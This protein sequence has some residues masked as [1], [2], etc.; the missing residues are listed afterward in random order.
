[1]LG[2]QLATEKK[3]VMMKRLTLLMVW[4]ASFMSLYAQITIDEVNFPDMFFHI[5]ISKYDK[6][7]DRLLSEEEIASVTKI[8]LTECWDSIL[9]GVNYFYNLEHLKISSGSLKKLDLSKNTKLKY[10]ELDAADLSSVLLNAPLLDTLMINPCQIG[11]LDLSMSSELSYLKFSPR[12]YNPEGFSNL[13]E[14]DL[15]RNTKLKYLELDVKNLSSLLLNAPLLDTLIISPCHISTLD[16]NMSTQ[17]SFLKFLPGYYS[18]EIFSNLTELDLRRNMKLKYLELDAK[19]L[20]SLLLNT[21]LLDT[22]IIN[23]CQISSLDLSVSSELSYL[24]CTPRRYD[25]EIFSNLTELDLSRNTKLQYLE[26]DVKNLSSLLLNAP[27]LDTL[28]IFPCKINNLDLSASIG[29]TYLECSDGEL[30]TL[31]LQNCS[32]LK[33]LLCKNNYIAVLNLNENVNLEYFEGIQK[34]IKILPVN[35]CFDM[36]SFPGFDIGRSYDWQGPQL[37][38]NTIVF[39]K[40][41]TSAS[42]KYKTGATCALGQEIE[43]NLFCLSE[44]MPYFLSSIFEPVDMK[45]IYDADGDGMKEFYKIDNYNGYNISRYHWYMPGFFARDTLLDLSGI[46]PSSDFFKMLHLNND[47]IPDFANDIYRNFEPL[48]IAL[49]RQDGSYELMNQ[50][51]MAYPLDVNNDGL[52]DLFSLN[53]TDWNVFYQNPDGSYTVTRIDTISRVQADSLVV[54]RVEETDGGFD[55]SGLPSL[56]DGMFVGGYVED[57]NYVFTQSIDVNRDGYMDLVGERAVFY[58]L[59][60]NQFVASPQPGELTVKDLNG[61]GIPDYIYN[62]TK[63]LR[64]YTRIYLGGDNFEEQTLVKDLEVTDIHCYDFDKDGDIDILLTF[65]YLSSSGF[66]F[67]VFAENKGD[68]NFIIHEHSFKT[69]WAFAQCLDFDNDGFMEL[70]AGKQ[71]RLNNDIEPETSNS[72]KNLYLFRLNDMEKVEEPDEIQIKGEFLY[73]CGLDVGGDR[74]ETILSPLDENIVV[75]DIDN[76]GMLDILADTLDTTGRYSSSSDIGYWSCH[77]LPA[78]K[79]VQAN[80]A[81][82]QLAAPTC[83][84][85]RKNGKLKLAWK[86]GKDKESSTVDLTYALRVGSTSGLDDI[87]FSAANADGSRRDFFPG[88]MGANLD[89]TL[90][91]SHWKR[92]TYYIA[93]QTVDPMGKGSAWSDELVYEHDMLQADF[94][95]SDLELSSADTLVVTAAAQDKEL[96][97]VWN[98]DGGRVVEALADSSRIWLVYD[99]PGEKHIRHIVRNPIDGT[100][101][102]CDKNLLI[103]RVSFETCGKETLGYTRAGQFWDFNGDGVLDLIDNN[104]FYVNDGTGKYEKL[105]TIFNSNLTFTS[106]SNDKVC[107]LLDFDMDGDADILIQSNKGNL[108][109]N[110]GNN[111]FEAK[112]SNSLLCDDA[113]ILPDLNNDGFNE[114]YDWDY[115]YG[116]FNGICVNTGDNEIFEPVKDADEVGFDFDPDRTSRVMYDINRDG[117]LDFYDMKGKMIIDNSFYDCEVFA[118]NQ[119]GMNFIYHRKPIEH[120]GEA[121]TLYYEDLDS[122]GVPDRVMVTDRDRVEVCFGNKDY[123]FS[124]PVEFVIER[125][126]TSK[127]YVKV[128]SIA[129]FDN[130][131]CP[132]ILLYYD[133]DGSQN[134]FAILYMERDRSGKVEVLHN[135]TVFFSGKSDINND[136]RPDFYGGHDD[137]CEIL[138]SGISNTAPKAPAHVRATQEGLGVLLEWDDAYDKETPAMQMRYN[139]SV[140]KKGVTGE[141]AFIISPLNGLNDKTAVIPGAYYQKATRKM[142]PIERFEAGQE[143]EV[144][145]QAIDLWDAH[146]PMSEIYTFKISK[147]F[148]AGSTVTAPRK[149]VTLTY[150]VP[151]EQLQTAEWNWDGGTLVSQDGIHFEVTWEDPGLK[152]ITVSTIDGE[153]AT[154]SIL[155][156]DVDLVFDFPTE[157]LA[158]TEVAFTLPE[159]FVNSLRENVGVELSDDR[160]EMMFRVGSREAKAVFPEEGNYSFHLFLR[161]SVCGLIESEEKEIRIV[162]KVPTPVI[163]IVGYDEATGKNKVV[164]DMPGM[165]D[166]VTTVN[167]YRESG[168]YNVF[169]C[170]GQVDPEVGVFVD[171]TSNP[172]VLANRYCIKLGTSFGVESPSSQI[173]S[174]THLMLNKGIGGAINLIWNAYEGGIVDSYRILRGTSADNLECIAEVSGANT[175]Y[176]DLNVGDGVYFYALEYDKTYSD[177][178]QPMNLLSVVDNG[179]GRSNVVCT[180]EA[181]TAQ[182]AE[183]LNILSLEKQFVL[184]PEQPSLHLLAEILPSTADVRVVNWQI[185]EG[186]ELATIAQNGVLTAKGQENGKIVVCATTVDGTNIDCKMIVTKQNFGLVPQSVSI[187]TLEGTSFLDPS[188][189]TTLHLQAMIKPEGVLQSVIWSV[190]KGEDLVDLS[191]DGTLSALPMGNGEVVIRATSVEDPSVYGD[192]TIVK[193]GFIETGIDNVNDLMLSIK[194]VENELRVEGLPKVSNCRLNIVDVS[195]RIIPVE[196]RFGD[197]MCVMRVGNLSTGVYLLQI[198]V[199]EKQETFHFI[200]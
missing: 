69:G 39:K 183:R 147:Q 137:V 88:N 48:K 162:G 123:T 156:R 146:S 166:F 49:S 97:Y 20:S 177:E 35:G 73:E 126:R 95:L 195:G 185:I 168:R 28:K 104:G 107:R 172:S 121:I 85:D 184:T 138:R 111:S 58:N 113:D 2:G 114:I 198:T 70:L 188:Y 108:I 125:A 171:Q 151:D 96:D 194:L 12:R 77:D 66:S 1:M 153:I 59:G 186:E 82:E 19:N 27:L 83:I 189:F 80:E 192:I 127:Y 65:D 160:I 117:Y 31:E 98:F 131:G 105:G 4:L 175:A 155:V 43:V 182:P 47:G 163:S 93:I 61:D 16:L 99:V 115:D 45:K 11:T 42:Y 52:T 157:G 122:D 112:E 140:K 79:N 110:N 190:E 56:R 174:G 128:C 36:S 51:N 7:G 74:R 55:L 129:D 106:Y 13:T 167:V 132:D 25:S 100:E 10:L 87:Y 76:D 101:N 152:T 119:G 67:L 9:I 62:D 143:Y 78:L 89:I 136:G 63:N 154:K 199:G 8:D 53:K 46:E 103:Q 144:Q 81:P 165:P 57:K 90:D 14:L 164:W 158:G 169:D 68:G 94:S 124:S 149:V 18:W 135:Q 38:G 92:G 179:V 3:I 44:D 142:I 150:N 178:W 21:P 145:V 26:L 159:A 109:L 181:W 193:S 161:D 72:V 29:L 91:V 86:A 30:N 134:E 37:S 15:S 32:Q 148:I 120:N 33:T 60:N 170:I 139:V 141:G 191:D 84:V 197:G 75:V 50:A 22:L 41:V 116:D 71:E 133:F 54:S 176:S 34:S 187:T 200:K 180:D 6:N 23:P 102:V 173:H 5:E 130:N 40:G 118:I 64:V 24:K 196:T 17:L